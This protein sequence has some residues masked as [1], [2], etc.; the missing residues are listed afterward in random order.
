[1]RIDNL[2]SVVND[3]GRFVARY[4]S[5]AMTRRAV[6]TVL[7]ADVR[8]FTTFSETRDPETVAST[9]NVLL[10]HL[11]AGV[12]RFGGV[13]DKFIGDGIMGLFGTHQARDVRHELDATRAAQYMLEEVSEA[14]AVNLM[15][16]VELGVG[17][18]LHTG[19]AVLGPLGPPFRRDVTAVGDT[20]N[21]ASRLC[22]EAGAGEVV[23]SAS[24]WEAIRQD[25]LVLA[26]RQ[27]K[28]K[29]KR[30]RQTL[31]SVRLR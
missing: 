1:M 10:E 31:Y 12:M 24:T 5:S 20:V 11:A 4:T 17:V 8:G 9:L 23:V 7:F 18:G 25:V 27:S 22:S 14:H 26:S 28:L 30:D 19:P 2:P 6:V 29:G 21:M 15:A 3:I 16:G 13:I